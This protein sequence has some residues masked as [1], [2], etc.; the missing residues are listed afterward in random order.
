M[1]E[2][3]IIQGCIA[4][5][6]IAQKALYDRYSPKMYAV[7]RRYA[8]HDY[9]AQDMLQE[10]F[11][12]VYEYLKNYKSEGS[13]EGW[14]R[15]VIVS[16]ALRFL[17]KAYMKRETMPENL[18]ENTYESDVISN[19]SVEELLTHLR[20]LP[21]Q[22][23]AVFNLFAIEGYS[24]AEIAQ[25]IDIEEST[26]RSHLSRARKI[27]Q[28][29]I[30]QEEKFLVKTLNS[31]RMKNH[32]DNQ[33]RSAF[34]QLESLPPP[35]VWHEIESRLDKKKRR[36]FFLW[37]ASGA[38]IAASVAT[39]FLMPISNID[40]IVTQNKLSQSVLTDNT[41]QEINLFS[42]KPKE[43]QKTLFSTRNNKFTNKNLEVLL[44][45][46]V[47][48]NS[49]AIFSE[50]EKVK[51]ENLAVNQL[52]NRSFVEV[53]GIEMLSPKTIDFKNKVIKRD[54]DCYEFTKKKRR[55]KSLLL[56][57]YFGYDYAN[58]TLKNQA[59][60]ASKLLN[61]RQESEKV[62][63]AFSGGIRFTAV[64][65]G[66]GVSSGVHVNHIVERFENVNS[67]A[68]HT[69]ISINKITDASGNVIRLDTVITRVRGKEISQKYNRYTSINIPLQLSYHTKL[70]NWG[71]SIYTGP[72]FNFRFYKSGTIFDENK[73]QK[74][75][76]ND[77]NIFKSRLDISLLANVSISRRLTEHIYL[78]AEPTFLCQPKS[79][80]ISSYPL[81]QQ[82]MRAGLYLGIRYKL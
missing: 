41:K 71:L 32:L 18:P 22:Y 66:V 70:S 21:E 9:E 6:R 23:R 29:K 24:H 45:Q 1:T 42:E 46:N 82:Y 5:E 25:L 26:S 58:K 40:S 8:K 14:I 67:F 4:G 61:Y 62:A 59:Q 39:Y 7:C 68:E 57:A 3:E 75:F 37:W 16:A 12:R 28:N 52:I 15:R 73:V 20:Q 10:G 51:N 64:R 54:G 72:M 78:L 63:N 34:E 81:S 38:M 27:L 79:F 35:M 55:S 49:T 53:E 56:D 65:S 50:K 30:M 77:S 47:N 74:A 33:Y 31:K 19:L 80:T 76:G 11:I 48:P 13:F 17:Q 69:N 36:G 44:T 60:E 43:V 2:S